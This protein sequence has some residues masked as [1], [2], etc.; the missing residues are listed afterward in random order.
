MSCLQNEIIL[1]KLWEEHEELYRQ[2]LC[3]GAEDEL[4][5]YDEEFI[6]WCVMNAFERMGG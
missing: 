4:S 2:L 1:E 3:L 5:A 6:E